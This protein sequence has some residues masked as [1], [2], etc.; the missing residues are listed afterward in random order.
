MVCSHFS[1][2]IFFIRTQFIG[3]SLIMIYLSVTMVKE[4]SE[5]TMDQD[6][7]WRI[8]QRQCNYTVMTSSMMV[9]E[10]DIPDW[11]SCPPPVIVKP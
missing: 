6:L 3:I 8:P 10:A 9:K 1:F 5:R 7:L 4:S 2:K 11:I